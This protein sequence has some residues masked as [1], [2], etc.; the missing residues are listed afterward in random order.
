MQ[1]PKTSPQ[2]RI[3]FPDGPHPLKY[4]LSVVGL[5]IFLASAFIVAYILKSYLR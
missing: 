2:P 3:N 1:L 4:F 5:T